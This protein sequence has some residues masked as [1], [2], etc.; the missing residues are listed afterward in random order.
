MNKITEKFHRRTYMLYELSCHP[1]RCE[2]V[3]Y[4]RQTCVNISLHASHKACLLTMMRLKLNLASS[5]GAR[6]SKF[7]CCSNLICSTKVQ[8]GV[9]C[10]NYRS[11]KFKYCSNLICSRSV[12]AGCV[13]DLI[14]AEKMKNS[15]IYNN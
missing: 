15:F 3:M 5:A 7:Q 2:H 4:S 6:S 9:K 10:R 13:H 12:S 8:L 11:S 1:G 14:A